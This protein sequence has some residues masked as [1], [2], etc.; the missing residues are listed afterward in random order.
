MA[1]H[2][3]AMSETALARAVHLLTLGA[4]A[5]RD[6][7]A[8]DR[9]WKNRGGGSAGSIF[10]GLSVDAP[11][12][13]AREWVSLAL[14]S[15]PS[16]MMDSPWYVKE[17][18][19]LL[20]L[21]RLAVDGG[22]PGGFISQDRALRSG[23][24]WLCEFAAK[25]SAEANGLIF[26]TSANS[27]EENQANNGM[28][29]LERR[30]QAARARAMERMKAQADRFTDKMKIDNEDI[31]DDGKHQSEN[32]SVVMV[33]MG[34]GLETPPRAYSRSSTF[35][36]EQSVH[37]TSTSSRS[38]QR[39]DL[40]IPQFFSM[41]SSG[42]DVVLDDSE[43]DIPDRLL[44]E[45]PQCIICVD[46][47]S[48]VPIET[49]FISRGDDEESSR[50]RSRRKTGSNAVAFVGYAQASTVLKGGGGPPPA[51][52]DNSPLASVRRFAGTHVTLCGH[53]VHS[54][55]CES[56]LASVAQR[57]ERSAGRR[58]EFRCPLC[59][60]L[61]NCLVPFIDVG[62]DWMESPNRTSESSSLKASV[63]ECRQQVGEAGSAVKSSSDDEASD[64]MAVDESEQSRPDLHNFLSTTPWWVTR[65]DKSV[66]WD[67]RC[68]FITVESLTEK[69]GNSQ[70]QEMDVDD[71]SPKIQQK[72]SVRSL[73]KKD[74]YAAWTAM[75][76]TPRFVRRRLRPK[77]SFMSNDST[78]DSRGVNGSGWPPPESSSGETL[79]WRRLMDLLSDT[80]FKADSKRL[81]ERYL[82][83]YCG[84][85]RHYIA[86]KSAYNFANR[87]LGKQNVE[88][89]L[90]DWHCL[91][92]LCIFSLCAFCSGL[93]ASPRPH[94]LT[95]GDRNFLERSY[96]R[97]C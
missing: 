20:L 92:C 39:S 47:A 9:E 93:H 26:S 14:M 11:A 91:V 70:D 79:V 94:C 3:D 43:H 4:F 69:D 25:N 31:E 48:V 50:K 75:M 56:Y 82:H 88:V 57:E 17:E 2:S 8:D 53:A 71:G 68:A 72:R 80:S 77:S 83:Q 74:L 76:R 38:P 7:C 60:R 90:T 32:S 19:T 96:C 62:V 6:A 61:S 73:R 64:L 55:C 89:S 97:S 35:A 63:H 54:E 13:T 51:F 27:S 24:A 33:Y 1:Y 81:G 58:E 22:K 30:K 49:E 28:S 66:V 87:E 84:E 59:Q 37:S 85:F 41:Y 36:S 44:K 18:S 78:I 95:H 46:D 45:R 12:P 15:P 86:E 21:R 5:W 65:N 52:E 67:G 16:E 23:A 10:H 29:D 42:G 40:G 34:P